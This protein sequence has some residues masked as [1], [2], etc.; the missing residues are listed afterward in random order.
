M[1]NVFP[2]GR[3]IRLPRMLLRMHLLAVDVGDSADVTP[4]A[5]VVLDVALA[6]EQVAYIVLATGR[7][8]VVGNSDVV[9]F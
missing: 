2:V 9:A 4:V 8:A 7:A 1:K 5:P 6:V 3:S